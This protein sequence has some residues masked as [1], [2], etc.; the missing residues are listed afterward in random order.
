MSISSN[1]FSRQFLRFSNLRVFDT[2]N[3]HGLPFPDFE[4]EKYRVFDW[5]AV[6]SGMKH[7]HDHFYDDSEFVKKIYFYL[8]PR[9][10]GN[11]QY[12]DLVAESFLTKKQLN[13]I[14]YSDSISR[15]KILHIMRNAGIKGTGHGNGYN[16]PL[17]IELQKR[18]ILPI[19]S[20]NYQEEGIFI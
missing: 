12:K 7:N 10:A 8:S 19:K 5:F 20:T 18:E 9:I 2:D 6:K 3:V 16:L 13:D 15:L 14:E 1:I 4:I 17:R 11:K